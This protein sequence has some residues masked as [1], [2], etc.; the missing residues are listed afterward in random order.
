VPAAC[1]FPELR[2]IKKIAL[3]IPMLATCFRMPVPLPRT[4]EHHKNNPAPAHLRSC[5]MVLPTSHTLTRA[6]TDTAKRMAW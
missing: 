1:S 2:R 3:S 6:L 4:T 5:P